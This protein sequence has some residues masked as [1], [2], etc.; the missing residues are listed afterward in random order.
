M[1]QV[2]PSLRMILAPIYSMR[3]SKRLSQMISFVVSGGDGVLEVDFD[4]GTTIELLF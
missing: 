4:F 3:S 2:L 1:I